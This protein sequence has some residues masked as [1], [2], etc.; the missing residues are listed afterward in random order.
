M[1]VPIELRIIILLLLF[2]AIVWH[3]LGLYFEEKKQRQA[4]HD[5]I[6]DNDLLE[7]ENSLR[8]FGMYNFNILL[9]MS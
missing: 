3:R 7:Y 5:W 6:R 4:L 1:A 2:G 8:K 9:Y